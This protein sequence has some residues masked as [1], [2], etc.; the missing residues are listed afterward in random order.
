MECTKH[1][2]IHSKIQPQHNV[3]VG[4]TIE[5]SAH[6][7]FDSNLP[8][9]TNTTTTRVLGNLNV[10]SFDFNRIKIYPNPIKYFQYRHVV[11]TSG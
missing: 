2:K 5:N 9:E 8:I 1:K 4:E 7:H 10:I 6:I 11:F 3:Q